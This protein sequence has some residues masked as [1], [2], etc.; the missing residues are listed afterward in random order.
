MRILRPFAKITI[1]HVFHPNEIVSTLAATIV[2][3]KTGTKLHKSIWWLF[4]QYF[5]YRVPLLN[6]RNVEMDIIW[7]FIDCN[8]TVPSLDTQMRYAICGTIIPS[9]AVCGHWID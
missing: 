3:A 4:R 6:E 8:Y 1:T 2:S 9:W 7:N 5:A